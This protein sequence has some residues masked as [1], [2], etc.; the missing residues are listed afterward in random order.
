M[1]L[2]IL[3][4]NKFLGKKTKRKQRKKQ[5]G[6]RLWGLNP[7]PAHVLPLGYIPSPLGKFLKEDNYLKL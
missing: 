5:W 4:G 3:Q 6:R 2:I 1:T 7:G